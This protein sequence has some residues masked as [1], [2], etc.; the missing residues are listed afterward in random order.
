MNGIERGIMVPVKGENPS[1]A[2][3]AEEQVR[4]CFTRLKADE[5]IPL[6]RL[7]RGRIAR[8]TDTLKKSNDMTSIRWIQGQLSAYEWFLNSIEH[9]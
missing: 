7:V 9:S 8:L 2:R 6:T 3:V 1:Q 4:R 5:F